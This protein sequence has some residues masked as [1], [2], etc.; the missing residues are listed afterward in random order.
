MYQLN[1]VVQLGAYNTRLDSLERYCKYCIQ[2]Y[3]NSCLLLFTKHVASE[4]RSWLLYYS[5][6]VLH[7][8]LPDPYF[9]HY[10]LLVAAMHLLLSDVITDVMLH[11]AQQYSLRYVFNTLWYVVSMFSAV[12]TLIIM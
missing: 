12:N 11:K 10:L 7:G 8:I 9:T 2:H 4:F 3:C 5:L 1:S 6:P